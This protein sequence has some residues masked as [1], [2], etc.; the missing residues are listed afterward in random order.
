MKQSWS[1]SRFK[2]NVLYTVELP[3]YNQYLRRWASEVGPGAGRLISPTHPPFPLFCRIT[4]IRMFNM[5]LPNSCDSFMGSSPGS[6]YNHHVIGVRSLEPHT[7]MKPKYTQSTVIINQTINVY[8]F[9]IRTI[10]D[11]Q[12]C[13]T[14]TFNIAVCGVKQHTNIRIYI[15]T[16]F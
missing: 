6:L 5:I 2:Q 15:T 9:I 8:C 4:G 16:H 12:V 3:P 13:C 14:Y 11:V 7:T 10:I 1:D